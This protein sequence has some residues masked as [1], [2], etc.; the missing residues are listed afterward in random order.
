[1][2]FKRMA[3]IENTATIIS[4]TLALLLAYLGAGVWTLVFNAIATMVFAMPLYFIST[5]WLPKLIYD[6]TAFKDVFGFGIFTTGTNIVN[7]LISNVDYLL[8]GKFVSSSAL[9][10]YTFAFVLTNTFREG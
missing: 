7:Y 4:G 8:I 1:M 9:G 5:K 2:N 10:A 6:K 3:F